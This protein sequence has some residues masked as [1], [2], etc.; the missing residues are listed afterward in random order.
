ML[1]MTKKRISF[2]TLFPN[3]ESLYSLEVEEEKKNRREK[4]RIKK[5]RRKK[6]REEKRGTLQH[7]FSSCWWE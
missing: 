7:M 2:R 5:K 1:S 3:E 4:K 6:R